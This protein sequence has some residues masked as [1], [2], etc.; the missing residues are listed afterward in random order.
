[1]QVYRSIV[2]V[3]PELNLVSDF[4]RDRWVLDLN[5]AVLGM[6]GLQTKTR[7]RFDRRYSSFT[8]QSFDAGVYDDSFPRCLADH[9]HKQTQRQLK[10]R[11]VG[12][13]PVVHEQIGP[14]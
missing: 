2:I 6:Q 13:V 11:S 1:M 3:N 5:D 9:G 7:N 4:Y 14:C 12:F 10:L 8:T